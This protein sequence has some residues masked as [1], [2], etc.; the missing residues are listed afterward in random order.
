MMLE[1]LVAMITGGG[2]GIG[3]ATALGL[4]RQ[5]AQVVVTDLDFEAANLVKTEI[6]ETGGK[7]LAYHLDVTNSTQ[8]NDTVDAVLQALGRIDIL[9]NNAGI[10]RDNLLMRLKETDW[11]LVLD[12]DLKGVFHCTKAVIRPM[13][14]QKFGRI[15]NIA[16]VVGLTGN[17]GQ[18]NYAAAKAGVI[19]FT[20]TV[21]KEV[22]SRGIL[23]NALA[24]GFIDTEMTAG[25]VEKVKEQLLQQ[26]PV[27][28]L[29]KPEEVA[30]VVIF[31]ASPAASYI[32]GQTISVDGGMVMA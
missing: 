23:V 12:V 26:I 13:L 19:G 8:V 1:D 17:A 31:L 15:I 6:E 7:A 22:A 9:V 11:D 24:P 16:S 28:R 14:K 3:R 32:T 20:K 27:A 5:G 4:A 10:S 2:R 30:Q 29:G 21:A 18:A 25:L